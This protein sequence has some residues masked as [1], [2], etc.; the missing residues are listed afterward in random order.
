MEYIVKVNDKEYGPISEDVLREWVEDGRVLSGTLVRN[1]MIRAWKTAD[2]FSFLVAAFEKQSK[3]FNVPASTSASY[4]GNTT[5]VLKG[6]TPLIAEDKKDYRKNSEF[7]NKLF[8][9]RASISLRLKAGII[10]L[11]IIILILMLSFILGTYFISNLGVNSDFA[12]YASFAVWFFL[13]LLYFGGCI[14]VFAQTPGM[15]YQ[16]IM[17][18]RNC[19]DAEEVYLLRAYIFALLILI[20]GLFSPICNFISGRR[21]SLHDFLTDT[22][23]VK[24]SARKFI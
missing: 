12:A 9:D 8:P 20:I 16:G 14:G 22:Q 5:Q 10:D 18:V 15:W 4:T 17:L 6:K 2:E 1:S 24:I 23:V 3:K 21:R 7:K 11:V 19:D 13:T